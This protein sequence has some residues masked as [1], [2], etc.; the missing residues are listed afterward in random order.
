[1]PIVRIDL[2]HGFADADAMEKVRVETK[3]AV[4]KTLS[5]KDSRH[6]YVVV[7]EAVGKIGDGMPVVNV[8]MRPGREPDRKA[9]FAELVS[10]CLSRNLNID[11][12]HVFVLYRESDPINFFIGDGFLPEWE[13]GQH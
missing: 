7:A 6:D 4:L 11:P 10:E 13:A 8:D 2:P 12:K 1:M 5:P 3:T 9:E